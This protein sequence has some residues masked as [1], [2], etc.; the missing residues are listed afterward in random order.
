MLSYRITHNGPISGFIKYWIGR[1]W[2][3][4]F[5][6]DV[7]GQVPPSGKFVV[8]GAPHTS[9]W[10]FP[11]TLAAVI[12]IPLKD[13]LD[14]KRYAFQKAFWRNHEMVRGNPY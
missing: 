1:V 3:G 4:V 13:L 8:V 7:V 6:W 11:F 2:M 9:G 5:G 14:G 12:Y 10:D